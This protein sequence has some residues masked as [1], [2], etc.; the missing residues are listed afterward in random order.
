MASEDSTR[1]VHGQYTLTLS[2][3]TKS[4]GAT[5]WTRK[6]QGHYTLILENDDPYARE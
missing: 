6:V 4:A 2:G 5:L 3:A 1:R